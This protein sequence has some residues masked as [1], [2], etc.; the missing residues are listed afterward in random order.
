MLHILPFIDWIN[1][2]FYSFHPIVFGDIAS[3]TIIKLKN[4]SSFA[5]RDGEL[6]INEEYYNNVYEQIKPRDNNSFF[7]KIIEHAKRHLGRN[8]IIVCAFEKILEKSSLKLPYKGK[9]L[10]DVKV[11]KHF[12]SHY[13][14]TSF[15]SAK[16][17]N[18]L[19]DNLKRI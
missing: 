18:Q 7:Y 4:A 2:G 6:L 15:R 17:K 11:N 1:H 19:A 14:I 8:I 12:N 10:S 5:N 16:A 13:N 9:H 3:S